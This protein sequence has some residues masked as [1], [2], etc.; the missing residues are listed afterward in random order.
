VQAA[1]DHLGASVEQVLADAVETPGARNSAF[2]PLG[3]TCR[4]ISLGAITAP[5]DRRRQAGAVG[6]SPTLDCWELHH[7]LGECDYCRGR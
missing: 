1:V 7:A 6:A 4:R 2:A 3:S 5:V